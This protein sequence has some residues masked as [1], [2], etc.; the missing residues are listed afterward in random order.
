MSYTL[1]VG[2]KIASLLEI[3]STSPVR[4]EEDLI[5]ILTSLDQLSSNLIKGNNFGFFLFLKNKIVLIVTKNEVIQSA[6]LNFHE[7]F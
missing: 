3:H 7:R 2:L 6:F 5:F 4:T 1:H